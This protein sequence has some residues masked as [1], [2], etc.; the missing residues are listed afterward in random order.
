MLQGCC[1][2][3]TISCDWSGMLPFLAKWHFLF[4]TCRATTTLCLAACGCCCHCLAKPRHKHQAIYSM[5]QLEESEAL[6]HLRDDSENI[7][8]GLWGLMCHHN[9]CCLQPVRRTLHQEP[10][11]SAAS[12]TTSGDIP[13][14]QQA[15][16]KVIHALSSCFTHENRT[17][18][19]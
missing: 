1:L 18:S 3:E 9:S 17:A 19:S 4:D 12:G 11:R 6:P 14:C 8:L 2:A 13:T 10:I 7:N 5:P 15:C 16:N